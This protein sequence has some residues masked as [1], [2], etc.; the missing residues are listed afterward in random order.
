MDEQFFTDQVLRCEQ[1][2]YRVAHAMLGNDADA[3]DAMQEAILKAWTKRGSLRDE[4]K[5]D[6]WLMRILVHCCRDI[7][8]GRM[9][10]PLPLDAVAE[11]QDAP[12]P[13]LALRDALD[14]I[15]EKYRIPLL[16]HYLEGFPTAR[17]A[18]ILRIPHGT[19]RWR[20]HEGRR[21]LA[22]QLNDEVQYA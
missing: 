12:P 14:R 15:P 13:D 10:A 22:Q 6:A 8:R 17:V 20:L 11:P 19:A 1:R 18:S 21:L 5:F 16:L 4:A 9:N 7:Q 3:G 2:L